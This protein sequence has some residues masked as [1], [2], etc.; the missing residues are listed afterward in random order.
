ML[1]LKK[2]TE[3]S[4]KHLIIDTNISSIEAPVTE[5]RSEGK[6]TGKSLV[7]HP[8]RA[9]VMAMLDYHGWSAREFDWKSSGLID[10]IKY[11]FYRNG[12][13]I[14]IVASR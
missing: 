11:G 2:I 1:L 12:K 9:A 6:G 8:S 7:G 5:W 10:N 14:T 13:R 4:A 3:L